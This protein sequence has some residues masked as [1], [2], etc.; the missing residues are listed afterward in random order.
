M[1]NSW[2]NVKPEWLAI[3]QET[4]SFVII[5]LPS[6]SSPSS[7][8]PHDLWKSFDGPGSLKCAWLMS[9]YH[10][11]LLLCIVHR[12]LRSDYLSSD[13]WKNYPS[14]SEGI[15]GFSWIMLSNDAKIRACFPSFLAATA[16]RREAVFSTLKLVG[17]SNRKGKINYFVPYEGLKWF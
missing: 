7:F 5:F 2:V 15:F 11:A 10:S 16:P 9:F 8:F 14:A 1:A 12:R 17:A 13:P 3:F 4:R 6:L